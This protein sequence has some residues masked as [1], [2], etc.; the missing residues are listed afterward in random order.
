MPSFASMPAL[1]QAMLLER[2]RSGEGDQ[3]GASVIGNP[4]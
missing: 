2:M 3:S 1:K 4:E